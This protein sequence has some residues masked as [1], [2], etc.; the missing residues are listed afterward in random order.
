M[1]FEMHKIILFFS[2]NLK[3]IL[4]FYS[5]FRYGRVT[6]NTGIFLS[7]LSTIVFQFRYGQVTLNTDIF[8]FGLSTI[9]S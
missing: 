5:K 3:K 1:H 7:G 9:I 6:L 2:E 8:L 4:C